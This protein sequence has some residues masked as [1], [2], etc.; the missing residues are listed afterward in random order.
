MTRPTASQAGGRRSLRGGR[1]VV[2]SRGGRDGGQVWGG[3]AGR[4]A[5]GASEARR[6][7]SVAGLTVTE[8]SGVTA[9]LVA[10]RGVGLEHADRE[11]AAQAVRG[12][13]VAGHPVSAVEQGDLPLLTSAAGVDLV[14]DLEAAVLR[15]H[16]QL[17]GGGTAA[18][19][20]LD[21]R[22]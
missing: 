7:S 18:S 1:P 2:P 11:R 17:P 16:F 12:E 10:T 20:C 4:P 13:D 9:D 19:A 15:L 5:V 6:G 3:S 21:V 22:V 14:L 8:T